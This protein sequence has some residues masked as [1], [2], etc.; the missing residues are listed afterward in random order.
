MAVDSSVTSD[1]N[2]TD[3][4]QLDLSKTRAARKMH[5][6][7]VTWA[8][9]NY[10]AIRNARTVIERQWYLNMAFYFGKQNVVPLKTGS[11]SVGGGVGRLYTPPAP[12]WRSR[13]VINRIRPT[14]RHELATLTNNKPNASI[15]PASAEDRDMFAAMAGEQIWENLYNEK[16]MKFIIRRAMWWTLICGNGFTKAYWDANLGKVVNPATGEKEGD[17]VFTSETPFHIL[18]PDFREE[19]LEN[20]PF[21]IHAQTKS[22]DWVKANFKT[23]LDGTNINPNTGEAN[24]ILEESFLNLTGTQSLAKQH[25]VLVMEVWIKPGGSAMF[26]EGAFFTLVGDKIVQGQQGLPYS[27]KKF[28]FAKFDHIPAGKFY[29][30]SSIVDLI[31]LQ[32]EFNRTRGQIIEAKNR[33][34]KPQL[35]APRGSVDAGKITSEPGQV[36]FF[37]PGF[38]PPKPLQLQSLPQYVLDEIDRIIV[39]W[40]DISGQHDVSRGQAPP[41]VTAATAISYLQERDQSNLSP[42]FDSL[43]EGIE[44]MARM[45]LVYAHDFWTTD[46]LVKITGPD[47]SFD[48]MTFKGSDIGDNVDIRIEAGSALPV[49]KAAKQA[50]IMDLMKMGFIDP[51]KGLEVMDM[52]G[53]TQIYAQLQ[54]DQKQ[55]Q[56]ENLRMSKVTPE[57][58]Q[59]WQMTAMQTEM[60]SPDSQLAMQADPSVVDP[61]MVNPTAPQ[62]PAGFAAGMDMGASQEQAPQGAPVGPGQTTEVNQ[63]MPPEQ[64]AAMDPTAGMGEQPQQQQPS[65]PLIVPVNTWDN[66]KV[67]IEYHNQFRKS[68]TFE[69]LGPE[70][71]DLFEQHVMQHIAAIGIE[72]VTMN[73]AAVAGLPMPGD[74]SQGGQGM[75]GN[76][77][78]DEQIA[79]SDPSGEQSQPGSGQP[80]PNPMPDMGGM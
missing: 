31:P 10:R 58:M 7:I 12:Y 49:S 74:P 50:L 69:T 76:A 54:V 19:E 35:I 42:T 72:T 53:I 20:Q 33:M 67:H 4:E 5:D 68:Q 47:G 73:P 26:P 29:S 16:K 45:A 57:M 13:P 14:V 78:I 3:T 24:D 34:S 79:K 6:D 80:G 40:N 41:G 2:S 56:R 60:L 11:S 55:A 39:D 64:M 48:V 66:H 8:R 28:P 63:P 52:G 1:L 46:R 71:K 38:D 70:V 43:E 77:T 9:Q 30:D 59:E 23:A 15:T 32:K 18:V 51:K 17:M 21:L 44:K 36:I 27:H 22:P 61:S 25:S 65:I 75:G 62:E 37:T